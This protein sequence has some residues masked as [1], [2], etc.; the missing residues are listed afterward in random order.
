MSNPPLTGS[1]LKVP[2]AQGDE[3]RR[4]LFFLW[5]GAAMTL[6]RNPYTGNETGGGRGKKEEEREKSGR[7]LRA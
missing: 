4:P 6:I 1:F 7:Q 5:L 3:A 2:Q